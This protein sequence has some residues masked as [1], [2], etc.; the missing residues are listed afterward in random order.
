[1][2]RQASASPP[3]WPPRRRPPSLSLSHIVRR[4]HFLEPAARREVAELGGRRAEQDDAHFVERCRRACACADYWWALRSVKKDQRFK[5]PITQP[6]LSLRRRRRHAKRRRHPKASFFCIVFSSSLRRAQRRQQH[7]R[8]VVLSKSSKASK[9][10]GT[11]SRA[12]TLAASIHIDAFVCA[13]SQRL[14]QRLL[15]LQR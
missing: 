15:L 10:Q 8:A 13:H 14:L 6:A 11:G 4:C 12:Y 2:R 3:N 9:Q 1:M 7:T 5:T